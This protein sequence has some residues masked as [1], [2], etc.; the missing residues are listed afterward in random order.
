MIIDI[1]IIDQPFTL[2]G[3][4][5]PKINQKERMVLYGSQSN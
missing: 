4:L 2:V 1:E 3:F 5:M